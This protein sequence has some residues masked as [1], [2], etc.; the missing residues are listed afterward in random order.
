[1]AL[2]SCS[3]LANLRW[4]NI[5]TDPFDDEK[6]SP[7]KERVWVWV[8][9]DAKRRCGKDVASVPIGL[10]IEVMDFEAWAMSFARVGLV[11]NNEIASATARFSDLGFAFWKTSGKSLSYKGKYQ[12]VQIPLV[13]NT[14]HGIPNSYLLLWGMFGLGCIV[15]TVRDCMRLA[16]LLILCSGVDSDVFIKASP[17]TCLESDLGDPRRELRQTEASEMSPSSFYARSAERCIWQHKCPWNGVI[18]TYMLCN[19]WWWLYA[20]DEFPLDEHARSHTAEDLLPQQR[21]P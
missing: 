5:R 21:T 2:A 15:L 9:R 11:R 10:F 7:N 4:F 8:C 18:R 17:L 1:M 14:V 3:S 12:K 6:A 20:H 19:G 16:M 13:I